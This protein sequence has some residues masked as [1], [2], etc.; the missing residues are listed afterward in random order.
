[1]A[2]ALT[3]LVPMKRGHS[4]ITTGQDTKT[5]I[6]PGYQ[7][8]PLRSQQLEDILKGGPVTSNRLRKI[9]QRFEYKERQRMYNLDTQ[10]CGRREHEGRSEARTCKFSNGQSV[11][12]WW[13]RWF[14]SATGPPMQLNK[15]SLRPGW[16]DATVVRT[17]GVRPDVLNVLRALPEWV[18]MSFH[19]IV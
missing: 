2:R 16:F 1:M 18:A 11:L 19:M 6:G 5:T 13:A 10:S 8:L 12:H 3:P 4:D 17:L 15:K 14:A 9:E 7:G